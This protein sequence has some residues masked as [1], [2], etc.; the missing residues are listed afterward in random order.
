MQVAETS[1]QQ[2]RWTGDSQSWC[3]AEGWECWE[4]KPESKRGIHKDLE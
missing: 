1:M 4:W 2:M 3:L